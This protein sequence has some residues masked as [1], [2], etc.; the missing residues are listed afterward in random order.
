MLTES[1]RVRL[2]IPPAVQNRS[3]TRILDWLTTQVHHFHPSKNWR[4]LVRDIWS[5]ACSRAEQRVIARPYAWIKEQRHFLTLQRL[6]WFT[7]VVPPLFM[8]AWDF[9]RHYWTPAAF[10]SPWASI[11]AEMSVVMLGIFI[12][13][14]I[15][16]G[17]LERITRENE[18][19]RQEAEALFDVGTKI[20]ALL[21][22]ERVL[23]SIAEQARHLLTTDVAS[24]ALVHDQD[25][26]SSQI[27]ATSGMSVEELKT[28]RERVGHALPVEEAILTGQPS[29]D[30]LPSKCDGDVRCRLAVPLIVGHRVIGSLCVGSRAKRKFSPDEISLLA[31][32]A[33]QAAI[34]I[35]NARLQAQAQQVAT[36]EERDRI[37]RE[38]HDGLGQTLNYL[39]LK[40][41]V[42]QE[43]LQTGQ[44]E[45]AQT[46]LT[47]VHKAT[48]DAAADVRESI[49]GLKTSLPAGED[50]LS[51]LQQYLCKYG[52]SN[53]IA[54][55]LVADHSTRV[56]LPANNEVQLLRIVQEA[57]ANVRKHAAA[58]QVRVRI[59]PNNSHLHVVVEDN[60]R[61]F[62]PQNGRH[63]RGAHFGLVIMRERAHRLGGEL[64]VESQTNQGTRVSIELPLK[65]NGNA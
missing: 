10:L 14:H 3:R 21:D 11:L 64:R 47:R 42:I 27:V 16:F 28:M 22:S 62:D 43:H 45:P 63:Q 50:W 48:R 65:A 35:E 7:V 12:F 53:N 24:I 37:A 19:R 39:A 34:A 33:N 13:S 60:G 56:T 1:P 59:H 15:I 23:Q 25:P 51:A 36:L 26:Q 55:E 20:T 40:L 2:K 6:K 17:I 44:I 46:E 38:L 61:G 5:R 32:L 41:D 9:A 4:C 52:E 29:C 8:G 54:T 58:T 30:V 31:R 57:L 18:H 49:L